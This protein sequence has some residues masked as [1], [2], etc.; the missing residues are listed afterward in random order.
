[1]TETIVIIGSMLFAIVGVIGFAVYIGKKNGK[2]IAAEAAIVK[3]KYDKALDELQKEP[4]NSDKYQKAATLGREY[5][6]FGNRGGDPQIQ[7]VIE[8]RLNSDLQS[9]T[10]GKTA[11]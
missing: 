8:T 10:A 4:T 2:V 6:A 1:M 11:I 5:Y 3:A 7:M 9:R